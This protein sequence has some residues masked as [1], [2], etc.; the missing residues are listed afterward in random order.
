MIDFNSGYAYK[1]ILAAMLEQVDSSLDKRQG[2]LIQTALGPGAWWL[3]GCYMTL[4]QL[5]AAASVYTASGEDLDMIAYNR[6]IVRKAATAAVRVGTF[7]VSIPQG[8]LFKTINGSDSVL[9]ASGDLI[10]GG[11]GVWRYKMTC[12]T[13]GEIGNAYSG[14]ILPASSGIPGL[15]TATIGEVITE[16][17]EEETD[18][19]VRTRYIASFGAASTGGNI[20]Q[21]RNDI[22]AIPGVGAV[23]VYPANY[24]NGG[25][26]VLCS[27][28]SDDFAAPSA[29][30]VQTVQLAICPPEEGSTAPS[31]A[32][33]GRAPVGAAVT[34]VGATGLAINVAAR[35]TMRSDVTDPSAYVDAIREAI[36][37]Y[38]TTVAEAWGDM[39][40]STKIEYP[41]AIYSARVIYA[42]LSVPEVVNVTSL[43]LNGASGDLT[44]TENSTTQQVPYLGEVTLSYD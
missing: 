43:T 40:A 25:G 7:N 26:T 6:G 19:S 42:I 35:I 15:T 3:E 27:I 30:L 31:P 29:A 20:A 22:L 11:S 38:I 12:Q 16:G 18:A 33:Y 39:V 13:A 32:G 41:V 37:D 17:T 2:S 1:D 5:Q 23:Q 44:L 21:Y 14:Q 10:S 36:R 8:S 4:A 34:I 24:Y 9:F 28:V